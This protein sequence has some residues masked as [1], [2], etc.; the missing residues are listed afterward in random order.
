MF[1]STSRVALTAML[2]AVTLATAG[3]LA[4]TTK[5]TGTLQLGSSYNFETPLKIEQDGEPDIRVSHAEYDTRPW[6]EALYYAVRASR[7]VGDQAWEIEF[8]HQKVKLRNGGPDVQKFEVSNGYGFIFVNYARDLEWAIV[9][10]GAGVILAF[11]INRIRGLPFEEEGGIFDSGYFFAGPG[12]QI[13][14]ER[15][16][17]LGGGFH[18]SLEGKL[19]Y[20]YAE[21]K[22]ANGDATVPNVAVHGLIGVG[23]DF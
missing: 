21:V 4:P 13:A 5:W 3:C 19:T 8:L 15:T 9:R 7:W 16:I 17:D 2:G 12:A 22:I 20:G 18:L 11:P 23:Y 10:V 1:G 6:S 14:I